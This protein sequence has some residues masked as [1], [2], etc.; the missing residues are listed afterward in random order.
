MKT[1]HLSALT[2]LVGL[3]GL[4]FACV[5][6]DPPPPASDVDGG[7]IAVEAGASDAGATSDA[8]PPPPDAAPDASVLDAN[9]SDAADAGSDASGDAGGDAGGDASS[10]ASDAATDAAP[11]FST[12]FDV[13]MADNS[14]CAVFADGKMKCWGLNT[15]Q[16]G[17]IGDGP[18]EMG[19]DLPF[20]TLPKRV[21]RVRG[22]YNATLCAI[23]EDGTLRCW[24]G[25]L[26][27]QT[28]TTTTLGQITTDVDLGAGRTA[29]DVSLG[30]THA[31]AVLDDGSVKC[32]GTN[33]EGQL[34]QGDTT[35][36]AVPPVLPVDLGTGLTAKSVHAGSYFTCALLNNDRL[37]CWGRGN[38]TTGDT[39]QGGQLGIGNTA[40]MGNGLGEMGDNLPFAKLGTNPNTS[41]PWKVSKVGAGNVTACALLENGRV[42]CW[43]RNDGYPYLGSQNAVSYGSTGALV[44]DAIPFVNVGTDPGT[45][46][47]WVVK[48]LAV[49][50][51]ATCVLLAND[52]I[53]CWGAD[54]GQGLLGKGTTNSSIGDDVGE[55]GDQ[56]PVVALGT[57]KVPTKRWAAGTRFCARVGASTLN[58]WG[59]NFQ[60]VL[61]QGTPYSGTTTFIGDANGEMGAALVDTLL[62]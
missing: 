2:L 50:Q 3:V 11:P 59:Q 37:K 28:G 14:S 16:A 58:C 44:D 10:D 7:T 26:P 32:W 13:A 38:N 49:G 15:G 45:S 61:G 39:G 43:G 53:R 24:G 29:V 18:N 52:T 41:Q 17:A 4:P 34:G 36:R 22:G 54:T 51:Y 21:K 60:G 56:L 1:T 57:G 42:K 27:G 48:D 35:T 23:F 30:N 20:M 31:C 5:P 6:S 19:A 46:Q 25:S 62:E 40:H 8:S 55:M 12:T 33:S 9:V 47:P